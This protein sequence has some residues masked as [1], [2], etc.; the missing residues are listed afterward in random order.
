M[1]WITFGCSWYPLL[2]NRQFPTLVRLMIN[3]ASIIATQSHSL[4]ISPGG[5]ERHLTNWS[6]TFLQTVYY[7]TSLKCQNN[8]WMLCIMLEIKLN[9]AALLPPIIILCAKIPVL[10]HVLNFN[11]K[12]NHEDKLFSKHKFHIYFIMFTYCNNRHAM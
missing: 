5:G 12:L 2:S 11:D 9:Y 7:S 1:V 8:P 10:R 3:Y 4:K 6:A